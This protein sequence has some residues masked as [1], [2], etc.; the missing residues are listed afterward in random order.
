M[1]A[2]TCVNAAGFGVMKGHLRKR[3][4]TRKARCRFF[5]KR[6]PAIPSLEGAG[7]QIH[8]E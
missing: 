7:S 5:L 6:F 2:V 3:K 1:P 8:P 4:I